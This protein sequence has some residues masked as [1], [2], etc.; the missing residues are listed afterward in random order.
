MSHLDEGQAKDYVAAWKHA[1]SSQFDK[2]K[3][4]MQSVGVISTIGS[5]GL[6]GF[7]FG[8]RFNK[9]ALY[10]TINFDCDVL[11]NIMKP[12]PQVQAS[13]EYCPA[14]NIVVGASVDGAKYQNPFSLYIKNTIPVTVNS[15]IN[16]FMN[17]NLTRVDI[18]ARYDVVPD[19]INL[20]STLVY[21]SKDDRRSME[22]KVACGGIE[23]LDIDGKFKV[24]ENGIVYGISV[25]PL[26]QLNPISVSVELD[27]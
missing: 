9:K 18:G 20:A 10:D 1:V 15:T 14:Q 25:A 11:A 13:L 6:H 17:M 2:V 5:F 8:L 23:S 21:K 16:H 4:K 27:I 3:G 26:R 19:H 12:I 22:I 24:K 7:A